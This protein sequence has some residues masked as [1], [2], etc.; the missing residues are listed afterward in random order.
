MLDKKENSSYFHSHENKL[1]IKLHKK[2]FSHLELFLLN[3]LNLIRKGLN[4]SLVYIQ[5]KSTSL[6]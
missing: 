2:I 5:V 4:I 3:Q 1:K 6:C